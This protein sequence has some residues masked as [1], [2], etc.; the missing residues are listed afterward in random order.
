MMRLRTA[1]SRE[2]QLKRE[3]PAAP[4]AGVQ[5]GQPAPRL[6]E[7]MEIPGQRNRGQLLGESAAE[8]FPEIRRVENAVDVVEDIVF[9]DRW[10]AAAR[11]E[12]SQGFVGDVVDAD[13]AG[14]VSGFPFER[15]SVFRRLGE[16][17][18]GKA[19]AE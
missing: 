6:R 19:L 11:P 9:G 4:I 12:Q 10:I 1:G 3:F 14:T 16:P 8:R 18:A 7:G 5:L 15:Q 2:A 13:K 17:V